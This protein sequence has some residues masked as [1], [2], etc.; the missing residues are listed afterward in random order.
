MKGSFLFLGTGGSAGI[1][2]IGCKCSICTSSSERNKRLR[3][4]GLVRVAG[5]NF[6]IDSG[7]DFRVQALKH[8][9]D[10]IDGLL[11]TH[12]HY[13]HIG[14]ID[15]L[16]IFYVR[17][18]KAIP[19]LLSKESYEELKKRYYYFF[20]SKK[21]EA[22]LTAQLDFQILPNHLG[23][24]EFAG[25]RVG[26]CTFFQGEMQVTGF[27]IGDFAYVSDIRHYE[28]SIFSALKGVRHLVLSSLKP[29]GSV[30]HF[31]FDEVIEFGK[32]VGA[33]HTWITHLGHFTD[34]EEGNALLPPEVRLAY[35]GLELEFHY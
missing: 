12:T 21:D 17:S 15:D 31:S 22:S 14:G 3:S 19:C 29:A 10:Q 16:R 24:T 4:S 6:L 1:P 18:R 2:E 11:L 34:H 28:D 26:Y 32:R 30:F 9:I 35:D 13:D 27:R 5:R 7:P 33:Q 23:E 20:Q 25:I 8:K